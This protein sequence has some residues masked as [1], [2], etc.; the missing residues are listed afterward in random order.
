MP[1]ASAPGPGPQR[2]VFVLG[3]SGAPA[4][5]LD[6]NVPQGP[7]T[8]LELLPAI[9]AAADA[10]FGRTAEAL[11]QAGTPVACGPGCGICCNQLVPVSR[12]EALALA[13][14]VRGLPAPARRAVS[15][16]FRRIVA[17][18]EEAGLLDRLVRAFDGGIHKPGVLA[19]LQR[20]YWS[21]GLP[22]PFLEQG[23]C[24]VH[25]VRPVICRQYSVTS[26]PALCARPFTPG[27][28][29]AEVRHPLDLAGALASFDGAR[30]RPTAALPLT[31]ALLL[32][33]KLEAG[34]L[35]QV[36]G[37]EMLSRFLE[38]ASRFVV[39]QD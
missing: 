4:L 38:L 9:R 29:L 31:L 22:C 33:K 16:R 28:R 23:S 17:A 24:S 21:L 14:L 11:A 39:P 18:L 5:R 37:P 32:E 25:P 8:I 34:P 12:E 1:H 15:D 19:G 36:P 2:Q 7:A 20:D 6:L 27:V 3:F 35:P 13:R 30:A 26:A 10:L